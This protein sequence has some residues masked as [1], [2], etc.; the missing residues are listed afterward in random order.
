MPRANPLRASVN[1]G[2]FSPRLHARSDFSKYPNGLETCLNIIPLPEGGALRR[3]GSRYVAELKSSAVRGR[4]KPFRYS[5]TQ[6]YM[7]ELG[8]RVIRFFR[9]QAMI[10]VADTD[11]AIANGTFTSN[12]TDW[13]DRSTGLGSVA[14]DATNGR[15]SLIPGG[16][17]ATD[18]GWAEQDVAIGASFRS[19]EHVLK[20]QVIG[21]PSDRV[22]LRIGSASTGSQII[23]D[24]LYEVGYHCVAFNPATAATVYIQFRNRGSFRNKTVQIDN[25]SLIDNAGVEVAS[26]YP[27]ADLPTIEGPQSAD[28]LY[29]FHGSYPTHKL[30]RYGHTSW[31]LPEVAWQDG[32]WLDE[33]LTAT[34]LTFSASTGL[35]VTVTAS[36]TEGVNDGQGFLTTDIGRL[37]RLTDGTSINWGWGVI[38][39]WTSTTV[40]TVDV[41]RSVIVTTAQTKWRLGAWSGTTGYP[42]AGSI[43]EQRTFAAGTTRQPQTFWASNTGDFEV[44]SPD[45]PNASN[46]WNGTVQDDDGLDYT[47]S[48]DDGQ[49]IRWLSPGEDT[50]VIGTQSGEWVPAS[51]GAVL[52]P[53]DIAVRQQTTHGSAQ[54]Q[55][56][57]VGSVVLFLQRAGRKVR[58]FGFAFEVDGYQAP[59]MTR[60]AQHITKGG[61]TEMAYAEEP[62]SLVWA[63]RADGTLLSM[64]YRRDEDVVGWARHRLGGA[65]GSG[66]AVVESVAVIP[67]AD[68]A[69]QVQDSTDRDEVWLIVKRTI[70]GQTKRYIEVLEGDFE[71]PA[72]SEYDDEEDWSADMLAAQRDAYYV[73]SCITYAGAA[74]TTITGLSHLE[75]QAVRIW[76]DGA[77]VSDKTVSGGQIT[78]DKAASVVQ[79]GLGYT[80]RA[81]TLKMEAGAAAGTAIG[82]TKAINGLTFVFLNSHTIAFGASVENL[83]ERD[84]RE[85]G[86]A[87]DSA[88]PLFTGER[89]FEFSEGWADDPRVIYGSSDPAPFCLLAIA[90]EVTTVDVR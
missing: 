38:V 43:F 24:K 33:N 42:R 70:N 37:I 89:F 20:F 68:G 9:H 29:L 48:A 86:H 82:K 79:I 39:G 55:P 28:V 60:L 50:L 25:V 5:D 53:S 47:L 17:G 88:A 31:S 58:E 46:V 7:A 67:G 19:T 36:S 12:I 40:V 56:V 90:P 44:F 84:F 73:D 4:L 8:D 65:F 62:N 87:M 10:V 75:G 69:G 61:I 76:A 32:P 14:H 74:A 71:G 13:D 80:H 2:E 85:V 18:I 41:R 63:V 52:T 34:T 83:E 16:T 1:G 22:E 23:A 11:A 3:A 77:V 35:G 26:P 49:T 54:V 64:T 66:I 57:R 45:S 15:L 51:T 59:D 21:A 30:Q 27:Q 78:L 72:K 6:A 81:K